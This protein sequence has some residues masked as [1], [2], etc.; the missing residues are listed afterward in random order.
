LRISS[1]KKAGKTIW[2]AVLSQLEIN[3]PIYYRGADRVRKKS[4]MTL[5]KS[6]QNTNRIAI[7]D[8]SEAQEDEN[9]KNIHSASG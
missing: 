4:L 3:N 1:C 9:G 7:I 2:E 5:I 8:R 6:E